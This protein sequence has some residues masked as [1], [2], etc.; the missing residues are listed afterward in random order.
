MS[1]PEGGLLARGR[2]PRARS[3]TEGWGSWH[4]RAAPRGVAQRSQ[5]RGRHEGGAPEVGGAAIAPAAARIANQ[6][7]WESSEVTQ[8]STEVTQESP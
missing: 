7:R 1:Q 4:P 6:D 8:K 5:T 3:P 2:S